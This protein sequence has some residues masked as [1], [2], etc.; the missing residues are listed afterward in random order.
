MN[1]TCLV[2]FPTLVMGAATLLAL[3]NF[4]SE[5]H[6]AAFSF[7]GDGSYSY[8]ANS[9]T[10]VGVSFTP[11]ADINV[12]A[13]GSFD[14]EGD[15]FL[16]TPVV[17]IFDDADASLLTSVTLPTGTSAPLDADGFRYVSII[18]LHLAAGRSYTIAQAPSR[19]DG[20]VIPVALNTAPEITSNGSRFTESIDLAFPIHSI[21]YPAY[22]GGP[23]FQFTPVP[24]PTAWAALSAAGLLGWGLVRRSRRQPGSPR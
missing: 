6:A 12:T 11:S 24:E 18:P 13:L 14:P 10:T 21:E 17:G 7:G 5:L 1:N 20:L 19:T 22:F 23:N 2:Q 8:Y 4:V 9:G 16:G 3:Q 15:G